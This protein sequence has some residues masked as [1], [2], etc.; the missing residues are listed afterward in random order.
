[1]LF[2]PFPRY[3]VPR[4]SKYSPQHP[5]LKHPQPTFLPQRKRPSFAPTQSNRQ[6]YSSV[7]LSL[8]VL[9]SKSEDRRFCTERYQAIPDLRLQLISSWIEF[10]SLRNV[11][12]YWNSSTLSKELLSVFILLAVRHCLFNIFPP[13]L[14]IW[15][16]LLLPQHE[17]AP[18]C[19]DRDQL[20]TVCT[21]NIWQKW[22]LH[23]AKILW[24][25]VNKLPFSS[26]TI[27]VL[28]W[29]FFLKSLMPY[30][31]LWYFLSYC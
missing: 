11:P 30:T 26:F 18:C 17:D 2:T 28:D 29:K 15:K 25:P 9:N 16:P 7:Y 4:R 21:L 22:F 8:Y 5:I 23:L 27:L 24:Q 19:G 12:K 31:C 20:I 10:W 13:T 14:Q 6:N 1:M 3:L